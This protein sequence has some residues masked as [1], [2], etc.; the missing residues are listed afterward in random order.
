MDRLLA[1]LAVFREL[2]LNEPDPFCDWSTAQ[3]DTLIAEIQEHGIDT[4]TSGD[5]QGQFES[6]DYELL[7][8][9]Y[10]KL[11]DTNDNF[12]LV[13]LLVTHSKYR[14]AYEKYANDNPSKIQHDFKRYIL[15][16]YWF[17]KRTFQWTFRP[18]V[19]WFEAEI[20]K[21]HQE[22]IEDVKKGV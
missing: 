16:T 8:N 20:Q 21:I 9:A 6:S 17:F 13:D 11:Q 15:V 18:I 2:N 22:F 7:R 5:F 3:L 4:V 10:T 19:R 1:N 12:Y 14:K